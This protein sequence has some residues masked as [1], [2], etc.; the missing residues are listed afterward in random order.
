MSFLILPISENGETRNTHS[1]GNGYREY[2]ESM[3]K[4]SVSVL[5]DIPWD[6]MTLQH[7]GTQTVTMRQVL[8]ILYRHAM[9]YGMKLILLRI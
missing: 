1:E 5:V 8:F 2:Y 7:N 9:I 4:G 3:S 6:G